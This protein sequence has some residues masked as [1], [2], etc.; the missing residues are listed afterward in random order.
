MIIG[1]ASECRAAAKHEVPA[2]GAF[3]HLD[4]ER[5]GDGAMEPDPDP[6]V[7]L[8]SF[9]IQIVA[10]RHDL[11]RVVKERHINRETIGNPA[12]LSGHQHAVTIAKAPAGIRAQCAAA[13]E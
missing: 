5:C 11:A 4:T 1:V 6:D 10:T 7:A 12:E 13:A 9:E 8:Q 3:G 2:F